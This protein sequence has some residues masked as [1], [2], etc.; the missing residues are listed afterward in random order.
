M[1]F[2]EAK[3][4]RLTVPVTA[5]I[6]GTALPEIS[7]DLEKPA[8]PR[9]VYILAE[10]L[11]AGGADPEQVQAILSALR[12][13][14]GVLGVLLLIFMVLLARRQLQRHRRRKHLKAR[15]RRMKKRMEP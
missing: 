9:Q 6:G 12:I 14:A 5:A 10:L 15:I 11:S 3:S 2:E 1:D 13:P 4:L 8:P 7:I